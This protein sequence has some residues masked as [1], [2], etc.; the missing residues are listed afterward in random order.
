MPDTPRPHWLNRHSLQGRL[1]L[2]TLLCLPLFLGLSGYLLDRAFQQNLQDA[3]AEQLQTQLYILLG[4]TEWE[5][6]QLWLPEQLAEPKLSAPQADL[7]AHI[8]DPQGNIYWHSK[9][10][11]FVEGPLPSDKT[12]F[13]IGV[14]S[15]ER[16]AKQGPQASDYFRYRYDLVWES[17][18]GDEQ[19]LRFQL[20]HSLEEYKSKLARYRQQLLLSLLLLT[21]GLITSQVVI[22]RWG[23]QPLQRLTKD[24][25]EL[26]QTEQQQLL[27]H[28]P[29][30]IQ[31]VT[32]SLNRLLNTEQQQRERYKNTLGDLAH[33]LK[34]PLAIIQGEIGR[35]DAGPVESGSQSKTRDAVITEQLQRMDA[36]IR[37]QLQRAV[38]ST[39]NALHNKVPLRPIIERLSG[40][41][42]KVYRDRK[43]RFSIDID[44]SLLLAADSQDLFEAFGNLIENACKYGRDR[45]L[46]KAVKTQVDDRLVSISVED[47]GLGVP[48]AMR[49]QILQRGARA[50][51][52][53]PGQGIGLSVVTDIV[54]AYNGSLTCEQ[55]ELGGAKFTL[56]LNH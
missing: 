17:E 15:F 46:I 54:S 9:S 2:A 18:D 14:E 29:A 53:Q 21:A 28:Y 20:F 36:I 30:E 7:F 47:N 19:A 37:Y 55:S 5:D 50:D 1:L 51:T 11:L 40:A 27:G 32:D 25:N 48:K 12:P 10:A 31:P 3:E 16:M 35:G 56:T 13:E 4:A 6:S 38:V 43:I 39:P 45:V 42:A 44:E 26:T 33:S 34:T 22:T 41:M 49:Q 52:A 23:L 24:L 8:S